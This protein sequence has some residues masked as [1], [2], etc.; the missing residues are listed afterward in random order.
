MNIHPLASVS[1]QAQLG[2]N[3]RVGPFAVV[4]DD[5]VIGDDC[6]IAAH[7]VVK[8][9][10]SLGSNNRVF[11]HAVVGGLP[12]HIHIPD[13]PGRIAIGNGNV[14]RENVTVHRALDAAHETHVG[15]GCLLMA[16][17]H[18]AHDCRLEDQVIV[19]NNVMLGGH[20][21]IE[22]RA[23]ISGAVGIHQFCRIGTLAI[24][25]GQAHV[26][27]DVPPFVTV[28]GV[29]TAIAGLN[30]V[31]LRR[32]GYSAEAIAQLKA[33]YRLIYRSGLPWTKVLDY[34]AVDFPDGPAARFREFFL[35]GKRGF[36][37]PRRTPSGATLLLH[38]N[39]EESAT[40]Q[41]KAG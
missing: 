21:T 7:V 10:T 40:L 33:A 35:T 27:R 3:V 1:P 30:R 24:V 18:V 41:V 8:S 32:A 12:Q 36:T 4:E 2:R 34:L 19:A 22:E 13:R 20:V 28:D 26:V 23:Y 37:P 25:G 14:I 16:G 39:E 11:E 15:N 31:G 38:D 6:E 29:A 5:V 17:S 9:G